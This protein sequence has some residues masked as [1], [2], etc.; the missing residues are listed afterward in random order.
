MK[1]TLVLSLKDQKN[2]QTH[3]I[4]FKNEAEARL[5]LRR[6]SK[7]SVCIFDKRFQKSA[8][9]RQFS[10]RFG[11]DSGEKLKS[12]ESF[13]KLVPAIHQ[14]VDTIS[15]KELHFVAVGG[16][17]VGDFVSFI[18][19]I[20]KR[21][22]PVIQIPTTWLSVVDSAHGGKNALNLKS[23]NQLGTIHYPSQVLVIP[24]YLRGQSQ[25]LMVSA[26][27]EVLKYGWLH[28]K[29]FPKMRDLNF[30]D[31]E[32]FYS[33]VPQC[34]QIKNK[35]VQ[36]DPF[37]INGKRFFLNLG[38]TLAH[39]LEAELR[40]PHGLA[41]LLGLE[42]MLRW[43]VQKKL[44]SA[45]EVRKQI[46]QSL[47]EVV[48]SHLQSKRLS[49]PRLIRHQ[50]FMAHLGS[51]KKVSKK[52]MIREIFILKQKCK[53]IDVPITAYEAERQRQIQVG[54]HESFLF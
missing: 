23:K 49:Y 17:S 40:L 34:I 4:L 37:E 28:R 39:G 36:Q 24:Q 41:V 22:C 44:I 14:K 12:L 38:H 5:H 42:F 51:D 3:T 45:N 11:V 25:E 20:Y 30:S 9:V 6:I 8:L 54:E 13:S 48:K 35:F 1:K 15:K 7:T 2:I 43:S 29:L 53:M 46:P 19:S 18:A 32:D 47:R 50:K 31:F 27:G 21:G 26:L 16:G 52:G 33:L 10:A